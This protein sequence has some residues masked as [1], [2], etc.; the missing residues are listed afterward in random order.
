[1]HPRAHVR[2][3]RLGLVQFYRGRLCSTGLTMA[4]S[5]GKAQFRNLVVYNVIGTEFPCG[6]TSLR[7][8]MFD[9]RRDKRDIFSHL[10]RTAS[11]VSE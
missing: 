7:K 3:Y 10:R 6:P 9:Q 11:K 4:L 8:V 1:M 2:A 5:L